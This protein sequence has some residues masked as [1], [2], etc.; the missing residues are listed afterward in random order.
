MVTNGGSCGTE[1]VVY[2][3]R[4][5]LCNK[6]YVG[7][8][9]NALRSRLNGH[10]ASVV[11]LQKGEKLNT[12]MNDCGAAEHF[13]KAGHDFDRDVE[14]FILESGDWGCPMERQRRESY[15]ICKFGTLE[16]NGMNN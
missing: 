7:E 1:N 10:R 15:Y 8:S 5:K 2:G 14:V 6:W 4:C 9:G 11:R 16:K 13:V 3:L 12:D